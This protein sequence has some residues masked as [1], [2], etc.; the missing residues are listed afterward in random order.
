MNWTLSHTYTHTH[1]HKHAEFGGVVVQS[2]DAPLTA[3]SSLRT[4]QRTIR[5]W[6]CT[7][8]AGETDN[9]EVVFRLVFDLTST[10]LRVQQDLRFMIPTYCEFST[11]LTDL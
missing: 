7:Q 9:T 2:A 6:V 4:W 11:E 10:Q 5:R 8:A 3:V 1:T